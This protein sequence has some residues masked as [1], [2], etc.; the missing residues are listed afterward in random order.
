MDEIAK[1]LDSGGM[2]LVDLN[3]IYE[4]TESKNIEVV[5]FEGGQT[6]FTAISH[7]WSGGLGSV[8][9]DGLPSCAIKLLDG[10]MVSA[11]SSKLIWMDSL[12][13]PR[14][15]RLR[16]L[17]IRGMNKVYTQATRT[18]VLDPEL[19]HMKPTNIGRMLLW[20]AT[21]TWMQRMW[22]L[23]E[24]RLSRGRAFF[25]VKTDI[26][27][28]RQ[29]MRVEGNDVLLNPV[30]GAIEPYLFGLLMGEFNSLS[31]I[32]RSLSFRTTSKR[33]DEAPA[34]AA[35]FDI[36]A[37]QILE[38][39]SLDERMAM[40]WLALR[41]KVHIPMD[42]LFLR[43]EKLPMPGFRWAP[44][45]LLNIESQKSLIGRPE[46]VTAY[47]IQ[48]GEDGTL[49]ATYV[50]IYLSKRSTVQ[51][52]KYNPIELEVIPDPGF[53]RGP[54]G[55]A[56][57][58]AWEKPEDDV[59]RGGVLE[60]VDAFAVDVTKLETTSAPA[61]ANE[62]MAS[63]T[64]TVVALT[65]DETAPGSRSFRARRQMQLLPLETIGNDLLEGAA[66]WVKISIS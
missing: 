22:T 61:L 36:D 38:T 8:S 60:D 34:L 51:L 10:Y 55:R 9:E 47:D 24:G 64:R 32:Q 46:G 65:R 5:P 15:K 12:C 40:F 37:H 28:L 52:D 26:V 21:A 53:S 56:T 45:S 54:V 49:N 16:K 29:L 3:N 14:E 20:V 50:V 18:L 11:G 4:G 7:V 6:P 48:M 39:R 43:G 1:I 62:L 44:R 31:Y 57:I 19:V 25:G 30:S 58:S 41:E 17:S 42:I 66:G 35:L 13:I 2:P 59:E 27:L 33:E 23:P 63:T